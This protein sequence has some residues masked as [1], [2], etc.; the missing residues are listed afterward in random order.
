MLVVARRL[1]VAALLVGAAAVLRHGPPGTCRDAVAGAGVVRVCEPLTVTDVRVLLFL[2][3]LA[4]L[5]VGELHEV[6]IGGLLTL[7]RAVAAARADAAEARREIAEFRL[8]AQSIGSAV[9][10]SGV[11]VYFPRAESTGSVVAAPERGDAAHAY[12]PP[13]VGPTATL[14]FFAGVSGLRT[15]LPRWASDAVVVAF[16]ANDD[17]SPR[18]HASS[19]ADDATVA[20]ARRV[21]RTRSGTSP[22]V[23]VTEARWIAV[24]AARDEAASPFGALAV[25]VDVTT[26]RCGGPDDAARLDELAAAAD[27]AAAVYARLCTDLLGVPVPVAVTRHGA[28]PAT[29]GA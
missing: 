3:T 23:D 14:A 26:V 12:S 27:V 15:V 1:A 24:A 13:Q 19:G 5:V 20:E 8:T 11:N 16:M 21:V 9:A 29:E 7:K 22:V 17:G 6:G 18:Y 2:V 28:E 10:T 4:L 25:I